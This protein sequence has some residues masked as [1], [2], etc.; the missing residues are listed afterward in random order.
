MPAGADRSRRRSS[1]GVDRAV[2]I[3][4]TLVTLAEAVTAGLSRGEVLE[5]VV[6]ATHTLAGEA[7]VHLW[8]VEG[9]E[10]VLR[11]AAEHGGRP[12]R[13]G[14]PV[15]RVLAIGEG[16]AGAIAATREPIAITA[17]Q[18]DV[19]LRNVAWARD[20]GLV[21][22]AGVPLAHSERVLGVLCLFTYRRHQFT[23]RE[24]S[25]LRSFAAHA[26]VAVEAAALLETAG[27]RLRRIEALRE[28]G[29]EISRQ[30]DLEALLTLIS[31]R[32]CELL[33]ADSSTVFL[34]DESS[35]QLRPGAS[36]NAGDGIQDLTIPLGQG[37]VGMVAARREGV[38]VND[39]PH[40]PYAIPPGR[41]HWAAV[42]QPLVSGDTLHGVIVVRRDS[43]GS[44][45]GETDLVRLGDFAVQAAI[46][47]EWARLLR[48][49]S[50][51]AERVKAAAEVGQ[52]LA[53]TRDA[54]RILDVIAEKCREILDAR[55]F[56]L[57]RFDGA[58]RLRYVRGFGL[59]E[60]FMREHV[61][62]VGEGVVGKAVAERRLVET[63]DIL[64]DA[65]RLN[66]SPEAQARIARVGSR[67]VVGAPLLLGDD[68]LGVLAVYHPVG[69]RAPTEE[70][71]F[72]GILASHA[73]AALENAR[74]FTE[75]RRRQATAESLA[76]ITQ[77][78]TGSLDVPTIL[79]GVAD[80]VRRLLR[81]EGG[82]IG[83]IGSDGVM[84]L[85]ARVGLGRDVFRSVVVRRGQGVTGWV[86]EH[87]EPFWTTNY[88]SDPRITPTFVDEVRAAGIESMIAAPVRLRGEIVGV[89]YAFYGRV[90]EIAP[91]DIALATDLAQIV[92]IAVANARLYEEAR[93]RE[94]EA[95]A[96][97]EVGRLISA[98]LEREQVLDQIVEKVLA[99][100][101]V[102][103]CGLFRLDADGLLRYARGAG[104]SP[105]LVEGLAIRLG[106]ASTGRAVAEG[107]P[108]WTANILDDP[109]VPLEET[110]RRLIGAEGYRAVLSV[111][112]HVQG[113]PFGAL[114][115]Y[116]W[117][118]HVPR[119]QEVETLYSL[120]TLAAVAI[121]NARLYDATRQYAERLERLNQATRAV[122]ASLRLDAVLEE[123]TRAAATFFDAPLVSLWLADESARM[124]TRRASHGAAQMVA[125]VPPRLA[126]GKGVVGWVAERREALLDTAVESDPR[127]A[128]P[129]IALPLGLRRVS[130]FPMMS[131]E[132]LVGVLTI[133][134]RG[135]V[136]L[137]D[138]DR[139]LIDT[140]V[141]Q[142]AAAIE[143]ARL[144]EEARAHEA[145]TA[146]AYED[147]KT[148]QEQLVLTE[149][150]RALGEMASG[151]AH[152]FNNILAAILGRVQLIQR[153]VQ[154]PRLL[155]WLGVV[156]RAALDGAQTVRQIQEFTGVR[157]DQP[158][159][160]VD[161]NQVVQ[162]AVEMTRTR[163]QDETQAR[164]LDVRVE[165][166]MGEI[167]A[168]DGHPAALR[169][170]LTNL[171]LN[172]V[173]ALVTG[174]AITITTRV[175]GEGVAMTVADTGIGMSESVRQRIF[176]PFFSTKGPKG[177]GLGLAM[178]YGIV[179]R[180]N[181][182]ITVESREG[183]GTTFLIRLPCGGV[184]PVA[185]THSIRLTPDSRLRVLV[186]DDES[187]VRETL[188]DML[189]DL[190]HHVEVAEHGAAGLE[191]F[192]A[193]RFDLV[194][195]DL[196]MP[197]ISGWQVAQAV[198]GL[199]PEVPVILVTGWGVE[200]PAQ[201]LRASGVDRVMSKPFGVDDV[202][203]IVTSLENGGG[204]P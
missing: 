132:R 135:T 25:L 40:S 133:W 147:L 71:E 185:P 160:T 136:P 138:A 20:Q 156:E 181:G 126:Y 47:L 176:E 48:L 130:G 204:V 187:Q 32:A 197:G 69:F 75:S 184:R 80:A 86:L 6:G 52:L 2:V 120:A 152:D 33:E 165:V 99:L 128:W 141:G 18:E 76:A 19:R 28:I 131:G 83:L 168:V 162:D 59:D 11:L 61:L 21:S 172:A 37:L 104:L 96:L 53:S 72:L 180:H 140:L 55:A 195:T 199:R 8:L 102:R 200:V 139:T 42:A 49:A 127:V 117:E 31:Q 118:P 66:L 188:A 163:W 171:I 166:V 54:D 125:A 109:E 56:G 3:E 35:R 58:G 84:R 10:A 137:T 17:V 26:A 24:M 15:S 175:E 108:V 92:A 89:L 101:R 157:R 62:A 5:R 183:A 41:F 78:V 115:T 85:S 95:R 191:R 161:L 170:A 100:M 193:E 194:M 38:L 196:A 65:E 155:R 124:L 167:P 87:D 201:Q 145:Q 189:R 29:Q 79:A 103:A 30:R 198:K 111:P 105:R 164:G 34:L 67:A 173:D 114:V 73:A 68:V 51:R 27:G 110:T 93:R 44:T 97:F 186:I 88:A 116:W 177:T 107:R 23:P 142:A 82:A 14:V 98:T 12:G 7:T 39:Y 81:S 148:A 129:E 46:A 36:F 43:V 91:E 77:T 159:Q 16:L 169:E 70:T 113:K 143:N 94:G 190:H 122:S 112:I 158:T 63:G 4:R 74:L 60:G 144:Y 153:H 134:R 182:E 22:F 151:V 202:R 192:R 150:L 106:E 119:S 90:V 154:D 45:F 174:G 149:K 50:A 64:A 57:F 178:V 123:I 203:D 146:R 9:E 13:T 1:R 121:E 179:S